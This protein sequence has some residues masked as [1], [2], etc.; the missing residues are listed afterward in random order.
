MRGSS[1]LL[2]VPASACTASRRTAG[3]SVSGVFTVQGDAGAL[4]FGH[5]FDLVL[6][7]APCSGLGVLRRHPEGKWEKE[8]TL[9]EE[10]RARQSHLLEQLAL[11]V[12]RGGVLVYSVCSFEPEETEEVVRRFLQSHPAFTPDPLSPLL[13]AA[14]TPFLDS[15]HTSLRLFP[16]DL[17]MDGG[18]VI[19]LRRT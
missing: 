6:C 7:D 3:V 9:I 15:S 2:I 1:S 4:P 18:F 13:P 16:G 19:R 11:A 12:R 5:P 14:L 17:E 8:E 10:M